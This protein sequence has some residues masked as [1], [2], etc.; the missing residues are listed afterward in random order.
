MNFF[1]HQDEAR[2]STRRLVFLFVVAVALL[3]CT[4]YMAFM[5][6]ASFSAE[7]QRL[8]MVN[9]HFQWWHPEI[10][11]GC[12]GGTLLVIGLGS[13][14]KV[15]QLSD[16]GSAVALS[17]GGVPVDHVTA[18][19]DEKRL[20]NVVEEMAIASGV[21]VPEVFIL[22]GESGINAFAAGLSTST[23]AVA[24]TEGTLRKLTRDELQGVIAHE[25][26]HI[27]NGDMRLNLRLIGV[28]HGIFLIFLSG[29]FML[30][31]G[32]R[33]G[34][35][36]NSNGGAF[37]V[38]GL[39][40][41]LVGSL[42]LLVGRLIQSA[43]SR[44]REFLADASAV[45]FTRNP[46]GIAGALSK[47]GNIG[48]RVR[49]PN[50]EEAAHMFF[51]Q[52]LGS[53]F[54]THPPLAE[55]IRRIQG[56]SV[57]G[58]VDR[59]STSG[60][61]SVVMGLAGG[62]E[63]NVRRMVERVGQVNQEDVSAAVSLMQG[64]PSSLKAASQDPMAAQVLVFGILL[65]RDNSVFRHQLELLGLHGKG[66]D[67]ECRR[68]LP[69]IS[70]LTPGCRLPLADLAFPALRKMSA[71]Q[72]AAFRETLQKL[73]RA[74]N[75]VEAFEYALHRMVLRHL[76]PH[77]FPEPPQTVVY[78]QLRGEAVTQARTL[79]SVLCHAGHP[80][81]PKALAAFQEGARSLGYSDWKLLARNDATLERLDK[82][83]DELQKA[84]PLLKDR[85]LQAASM[86]ISCDGVVTPRE[87]EL[88]R[89]ISDA[90]DCPIPLAA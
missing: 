83:L 30:E 79:L 51:G 26:S 20:L 42:G 84:A 64:L 1:Q 85:I 19:P 16:G 29:R 45:Q 66:F 59:V 6:V 57:E 62:S 58:L 48:S 17:L 78:E 40:L 35:S 5:L 63:S 11:A 65:S 52:A 86:A 47:I 54:A 80:T 22:P 4:T 24:V 87:A 55:R 32:G 36:K 60:G 7:G 12:A 70:A 13:L 44:Q 71:Q 34:R 75:K 27:F 33:S 43:V 69:E 74:D 61:T 38:A 49:H 10:F 53:L 46:H 89:A 15:S 8:L 25:F 68:L 81:E 76:Q 41:M 14:W 31:I 90:L 3:S 50:A 77:Y 82:A 9:G 88:F 23:A 18:G 67:R 21:P 28:L 72:F 2:S 56:V 73:I 39:V 37:I